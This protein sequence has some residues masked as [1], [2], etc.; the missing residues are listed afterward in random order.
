MCETTFLSFAR[1]Y[2]PK[3][4]N[5]DYKE[6]SLPKEGKSVTSRSGQNGSRTSCGGVGCGGGNI[7]IQRS[8][9]TLCPAAKRG[10]V[11]R[12]SPRWEALPATGRPY[13]GSLL[14]VRVKTVL[15]I[16]TPARGRYSAERGIDWGKRGCCQAC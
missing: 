12:F 16:T 14:A 15:P 7:L 9:K 6:K 4:E 5:Q 13:P 10:I 3:G 2:L 8:A 1:A 11:R